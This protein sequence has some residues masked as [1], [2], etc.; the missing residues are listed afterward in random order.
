LLVR[1]RFVPFA[2]IAEFGFDLAPSGAALIGSELG[3]ESGSGHDQRHV[4]MPT[5]PGTSLAMV[6]PEIILGAQKAFLDSPA[7]ARRSGQFLKRGSL[8]RIDEIVGDLVGGLEIAAEE[9]LAL[10]AVA[11]RPVE[12]QACPLIQPRPLGPFACGQRMPV[13]RIQFFNKAGRIGLDEAFLR[14]EAQM[15]VGAHMLNTIAAMRGA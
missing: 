10:E 2:G 1:A 7:Q 9:Q 11:R 13:I 5:M 3:K 6:K 14:Q 12:R 4:T 15:L 8:A